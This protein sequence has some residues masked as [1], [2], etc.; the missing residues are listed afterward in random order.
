KILRQVYA[1]DKE[2]KTMTP[3]LRLG[4]HKQHS[5]PL[6]E[7]LLI[8]LN[9]QFEEHLVEPNSHLGKSIKYLLNHWH[10]LTQFMRVEGMPIDNNHV[11][12]AL[13]L[14]I[15]TRKMALF[16]KT[17]HGAYVGSLI[18]SLIQTAIDNGVNPIEYLTA[19]QENKSRVFKEPSLWVPW[20]YQ[21][22]LPKN[23]PENQQR[24][25]PE[26]KTSKDRKSRSDP[27]SFSGVDLAA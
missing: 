16:H 6:M 23:Q 24:I 11:E 3:A 5:V 25:Q 20:K 2:A 17:E 13:K 14:P 8:W 19:A 1:H 21:Y 10:A 26:G 4:H 27:A 15:R 22:Q 12:R 7:D 18:M 9:R